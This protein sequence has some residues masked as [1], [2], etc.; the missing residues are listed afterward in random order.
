MCFPVSRVPAAGAHRSRK[1][2]LTAVNASVNNL[3]VAVPGPKIMAHHKCSRCRAP[4]RCSSFTL[5]LAALAVC[6]GAHAGSTN[7]DA[8][9]PAVAPAAAEEMPKD[10]AQRLLGEGFR[11]LDE[12]DMASAL[13]RFR[14]AYAVFPRANLLLNIAS[15]LRQVGKNAEAAAVYRRYLAEP[16]ASVVRREQV[17]RILQ[18]IA[19]VVGKVRVEVGAAN[20]T[21]LIDGQS[22]VG[23][24]LRSVEVDAGKHTIIATVMGRPRA[25]EIVEVAAG[26]ELSLVLNMKEEAPPR[27]VVVKDGLPPRQVAGALLGALGLAAIGVGSGFGIA[28]IHDKQA[29]K[30]YCTPAFTVCDPR[31]EKLADSATFK[32]RASTGAFMVGGSAALVGAV[33]LVLGRR[34]EAPVKAEPVVAL[35]SG[36]LWLGMGG[37]W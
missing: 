11:L 22:V 27:L 32:A 7:E 25:I 20:V 26:R 18:E 17:A 19:L 6:A 1:R 31:A 28:A 36:S 12:G 10:A 5:A 15:T 8:T 21:L 3:M 14:G 4:R 34:S 2:T 37:A 16:G 23:G 13:V 9:I 33:L 35:G 24:P 30:S 29:L